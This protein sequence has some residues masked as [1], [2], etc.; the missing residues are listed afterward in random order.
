[1]DTNGESLR[2]RWRLCRRRERSVGCAEENF[3]SP[4]ACSLLLISVP[5]AKHKQRVCASVY[6]VYSVCD[7]KILRE[8][9]TVLSV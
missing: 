3:S 7:K 9:K 8:R 4:E 1:M 5:E 2:P 6:F